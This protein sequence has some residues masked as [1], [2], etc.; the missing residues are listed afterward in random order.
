MADDE[1]DLAMKTV[2]KLLLSA[3]HYASVSPALARFHMLEA[4]RLKKK[5]HLPASTTSQICPHCFLIR[6]PDN[7]TRR[8]LPRMKTGRRAR[9]LERKSAGD[10]TV[11]KFRK[12]LV[13]LHSD[14]ANR[15]RI[16]CHSCRKQ[17]RV[18]GARRPAKVSQASDL[19]VGGNGM[20]QVVNR[21]KKRRRKK[22]RTADSGTKAGNTISF[23]GEEVKERSLEKCQSQTS[24][25]VPDH[26]DK[27][28]VRN[29]K[30]TQKQKHNM[31]Q[32]ILKQ[33]TNTASP[34][35]SA[36]LRSFL[37]SL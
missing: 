16:R 7:C 17:V 22:K 15:L 12:S 2:T 21:K 23:V 26:C 27:R 24:P 4:E 11:G 18:R 5:L 20:E 30:E 33:K 13:D 37:M 32:N 1:E 28:R 9:R 34:D 36:A 14:G 29:K 3:E 6:R 19:A 25:L 31:L 10:G 35:T 8:L